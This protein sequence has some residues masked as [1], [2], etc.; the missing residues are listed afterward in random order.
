MPGRK[1]NAGAPVRAALIVAGGQGTRFWPL[2]R[3]HR[4]K[5]LFRLNGTN[6]LLADTVERLEPIIGRERI[7]VIAPT[8]FKTL[9]ARELK[10][11][12]PASNLLLEPSAR[13][14][15]VAVAYGCRLIAERLGEHLVVVSPADHY[16]SPASAF[17]RTISRALALAATN[18][19]IVLIGVVPTRPEVGYGYLE[20]GDTVGA[21][22][23]VRRFV[24]KPKA[25]MARRMVRSG[26]FLWNAGIFVMHT[27]TLWSAL[28]QHCPRLYGAVTKIDAVSKDETARLFAR[29]RFASFDYEILEKST[30]LLAVPA[31]F[32]WHDIGSWDGL[33]K[34]TSAKNGNSLSGN[35]LSL[36]SNRVLAFGSKRLMVLLG[37]KDLVA[38]DTDD[39]ILIASRS[40]S[41]QVRKVVEE[42]RRRRMTAYL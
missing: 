18:P 35:V 15:A 4:P 38:V 37:V 22:F 25:A 20:V 23:A 30:N 24:E 41:E 29:L 1:T 27:E 32:Q 33:W 16:V 26:N 12:I 9:F 8:A 36:A 40:H 3:A 19:A 10:G 28:R 14:T 2:S 34:A 42:L 17:R 39:A 21:G 13:G 7:F 6:S 11:L 5:P 31:R